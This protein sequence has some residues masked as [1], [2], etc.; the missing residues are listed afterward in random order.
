MKGG[1]GVAL[2]ARFPWCYNLSCLGTKAAREKY[3]VKRGGSYYNQ[4]PA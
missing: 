2:G 4:E 1:E 3:I